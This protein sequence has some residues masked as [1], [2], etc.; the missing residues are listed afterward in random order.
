M[1]DVR[2]Q[3][4][5][6]ARDRAVLGVRVAV[7]DQRPV[8]IPDPDAVVV[9]VL[10]LHDIAEYQ[11]LGARAAQQ[12]RALGPIDGQHEVRGGRGV[13]R[14]VEG[15]RDLDRLVDAVGVRRRHRGGGH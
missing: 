10:G 8:L 15:H 12:R 6:H 7:T 13:H 4:R 14:L 9:G 3:A 11:R 1:G 5:G 2:R